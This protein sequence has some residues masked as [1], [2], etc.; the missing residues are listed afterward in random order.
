[1]ITENQ[2][3]E[4]KETWRDEYI[5]WIC[6]FANAQGGTLIIGKNDRGELVGLNDSQQLAEE[7]PN[8]VRDLLGIMVDVNIQ[9]EQGKQYLEITVDP[10]PYPINYK[11]QY[12]YR[13]GSTKQELKGNALNKFILQ[14]T[15]RHWDSI[16]LPN[17]QVHDLDSS[18]FELFRKKAT[19]A[20][21]VDEDTLNESNEMLLHHLHLTENG[22]LKRATALLFHSD[23]ERFI[24]GSYVKIGYFES[25]SDLIYHD[26][27]HGNL[28][29]QAEKTM[30]LL[31]TKYMKAKIS[32]EGITRIETFLFPEAA[33]RE[34]VINAIVHKEYSSGIPVQIKVFENRIRIWNDGQLPV[35]WSLDN[36]YS[37][38]PSKPNNPDVANAFFRAGMIESWGRGIDKIIDLCT[39]SGL[40]QP[41]FDTS[42]GGL[43]IEFVA[44]PE[45]PEIKT[46]E[47]MREKMRE[48]M[49][50]KTS[51]KIL[52]L[53]KDNPEITIKT[54]TDQTGKSHSTIE[55]NLQK[56]QKDHRIERIGPD[57]GGYWKVIE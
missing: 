3:M 25:E 15:G 34:A 16:P 55:R 8:K 10:Y 57:K 14:K 28:F 20:K 29:L 54:L 50:E 22:Q 40:P 11:G 38:H 21:R 13:S 19:R 17:L 42:F 56:L 1:M 6:G 43:Q 39:L 9:D 2:N 41:V 52:T 35:D 18:A 24:T 12:H 23:P 36:L 44:N 7:I 5:K 32:Y 51:D 46:S 4:W 49:G 37:A 30:E 45:N 48:K 31:L 33:L 47:K 53:I 26:E 27:I